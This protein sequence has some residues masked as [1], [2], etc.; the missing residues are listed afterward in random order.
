MKR[1][2]FLLLLT[3]CGEDPQVSTQTHFTSV[4]PD[5]CSSQI[6]ATSERDEKGCDCAIE[7]EIN[8]EVM[9]CLKGAACD[10]NEL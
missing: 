8:P 6:I 5:F 1:L 10:C 3:A 9:V 7:F 2:V 4:G